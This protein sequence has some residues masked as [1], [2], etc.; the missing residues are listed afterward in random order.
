MLAG[1]PHIVSCRCDLLIVGWGLEAPNSYG[2]LNIN[3]ECIQGIRFWFATAAVSAILMAACGQSTMM[4]DHN[5]VAMSDQAAMSE[6][7]ESMADSDGMTEA[8]MSDSHAM[9]DT[10]MAETTDMAMDDST[11]R[12]ICPV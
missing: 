3:Y 11:H 10:M 2:N 4:D 12:C 6:E 1:I 7:G 9:T 5:D 8:M